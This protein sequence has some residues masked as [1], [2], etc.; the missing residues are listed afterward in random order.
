[1]E[2][3]KSK[4]RAANRT[5]M[6]E[7]EFTTMKHSALS[8]GKKNSVNIEPDVDNTN[9]NPIDLTINQTVISEK[10]LNTINVTM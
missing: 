9:I 1:M 10:P 8:G 2:F 7:A 4:D 3:K 5:S 6:S